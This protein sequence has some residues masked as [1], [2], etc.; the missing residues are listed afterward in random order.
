VA[1]EIAKLMRKAAVKRPMPLTIVGGVTAGMLMLY[2]TG[3]LIK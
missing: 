1:Y 3:V 2:G